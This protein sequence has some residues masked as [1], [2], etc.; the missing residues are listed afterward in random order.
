MF[1]SSRAELCPGEVKGSLAVKRRMRLKQ[2]PSG[3]RLATEDARGLHREPRHTLDMFAFSGVEP[4]RSPRQSR[5][6]N[7]VLFER[8]CARSIVV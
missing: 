4:G 5:F 3:F 7:D 2:K 8:G 6:R 1:D